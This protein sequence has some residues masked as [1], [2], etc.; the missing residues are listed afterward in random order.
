MEEFLCYVM[1]VAGARARQ[2]ATKSLF[3]KATLKY[4]QCYGM[5]AYFMQLG[6]VLGAKHRHNLDAFG[7]A[8]LGVA[9]PP[10]TVEQSFTSHAPDVA[11][12]VVEGMTFLDYLSADQVRRLP[13]KGDPHQLFLDLGP[14]K[15]DLDAALTMLYEYALQG[16]ILGATHPELAR[17]MFERTHAPAD[18]GEWDHARAAGLDIPEKQD[19][20]TYEECEEGEN[21]AFMAYC[22]QRAPSLYA[23]LQG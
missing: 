9:G 20:M 8:F 7:H 18:Q 11:G 17:R 23:E 13:Y 1:A 14:K 19:I 2:E 12:S 5:A 10:G 21:E 22:Q 16:A 3:G 4:G 15:V 6:S